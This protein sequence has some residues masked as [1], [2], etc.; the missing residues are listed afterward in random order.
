MWAGPPADQT[1]QLRQKTWPLFGTVV[2]PVLVR[3]LEVDWAPLLVEVVYGQFLL[4]PE[5]SELAA[6]MAEPEV[7]KTLEDAGLELV[8]LGPDAFRRLVRDEVG[9]FKAV[10]QR[11]RI[12]MD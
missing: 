9:T 4:L 11:A 7:R 10:A 1:W 5:S 12:T 6:V 2:L 3:R 8:M